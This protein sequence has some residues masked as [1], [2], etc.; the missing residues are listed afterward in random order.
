MPPRDDASLHVLEAIILALLLM[1]AAHTVVSLRD[2]SLDQQRPRASLERVAE[3]AMT[4]LSGLRDANGS[5]L[6]AYVLEAIHCSTG[7]ADSDASAAVMD[8]SGGGAASVCSGTRSA[9]LSL[10]LESYLPPGA[11]YAFMLDNGVHA[12]ELH[13]SVLA[14]GETVAASYA[15]VPSWNLTFLS[16][17]LSCYEPGMDVN[18]SAIPIRRGS[19]G[20]LTDLLL[21]AG[22]VDARA[23]AA[24]LPG[25]WNVTLPAATRPEQG[26]LVA[27]ATGRG[28]TYP[29]AITL[30]SCGLGGI[31]DALV[32]AL[33]GAT[34]D[35]TPSVVPLG[36][37][38][39][40]HV[41]LAPVLAIPGVDLVAANVTLVEPL[42]ALGPDAYVA[43][44]VLDVLPEGKD[45]LE[46]HAP[47][48]ALYGVHPV[49]LKAS[50]RV[51][52][53]DVV[54]I[55]RVSTLTVALPDGTVPLDPP[56][57]VV[58]QAWFPDW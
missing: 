9:N 21:R 27:H 41:D 25:A 33:R 51:P 6:D 26:R 14:P 53:G 29:G 55:R 42:P 48:D 30:S 13:R 22:D 31:G 36:G 46:W 28:A 8:S 47:P 1:G 44:A 15:Y 5:L 2:S 56:Y 58:L 7:A 57:R 54:E 3:D 11:G 20:N 43:A 52:G 10:K 49:V 38:A 32:E 16:T 23:E 34:L 45:A 35:V 40:F 18:V 12:R 37:R 50:L 39:D 19:L 4:V 17:E 24:Q